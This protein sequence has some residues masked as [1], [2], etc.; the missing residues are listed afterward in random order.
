M[1]GKLSSADSA[2]SVPLSEKVDRINA[3]TITGCKEECVSWKG[4]VRDEWF[5]CDDH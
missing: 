1:E 3:R 5:I 4:I 2:G